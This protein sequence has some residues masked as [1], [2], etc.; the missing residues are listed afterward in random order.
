MPETE[1]RAPL[2][3]AAS[4]VRFALA[5]FR[6][7]DDGGETDLLLDRGADVRARWTAAGP[8]GLPDTAALPAAAGRAKE[9]AAAPE[10]HAGHV[11]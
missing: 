10:S 5:L 1:P 11:H 8:H 6:A 3:A 2:V 4:D 7:P 9:F